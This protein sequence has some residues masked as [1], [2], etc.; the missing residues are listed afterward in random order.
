METLNLKSHWNNAYNKTDTDKLGWYE[1]NCKPSIDLIKQCNLPKNA[2]ILNVGAGAT[3]LIDELI[4][5][6]FSNLIASDISE[7]ALEKLKKRLSENSNKVKFI[8]DDL[9]NSTVLNN[10]EPIDLWHDRAVLHFFNESKEQDTYFKLL[11]K[12]IKPKGYAI[13]AVFNLDGAMKCCGLPVHRY[14]KSMLEEKMGDDF[15]LV[16]NFNH[17]FTNPSGAT[18]EYVY[19]LFQKK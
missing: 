17:T 6:G 14:D 11:K 2:S 13:I 1:N 9:N 12:L 5:L 19:T 16:S 18:R 10:L 7:S 8:V 3:L 15:L 4:A